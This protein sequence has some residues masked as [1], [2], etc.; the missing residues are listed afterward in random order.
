MNRVIYDKIFG[1]IKTAF[2]AGWK[3]GRYER[4]HFPDFDD[5]WE[6]YKPW[7]EK[8]FD[9]ILGEGGKHD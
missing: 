7:L 2:G 5:A 6:E 8:W 4:I 1:L 9:A 3:F